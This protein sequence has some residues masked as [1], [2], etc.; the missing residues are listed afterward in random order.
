MLYVTQAS[1]GL[2]M[3]DGLYR[4]VTHYLV[5]GFVIKDGKVIAIAPILRRKFEYWRTVA[6]YVGE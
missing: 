1:N 5:A 6:E 3:K 4:V 2:V